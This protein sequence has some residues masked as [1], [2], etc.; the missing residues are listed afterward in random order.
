MPRLLLLLCLIGLGSAALAAEPAAG[1][2]T[3]G[4]GTAITPAQARQALEV[5]NDP[6]KRAQFTATLE[7]IVKAQPAPGAAPAAGP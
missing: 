3:A 2:G 4:V 5:L 7:A 6:Q 1:P